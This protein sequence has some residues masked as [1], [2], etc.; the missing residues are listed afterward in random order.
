VRH[1]SDTDLCV[2]QASFR[3]LLKL[4]HGLLMEAV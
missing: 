3:L 1:R 2:L 4:A